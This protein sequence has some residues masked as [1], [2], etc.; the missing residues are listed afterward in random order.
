[1]IRFERSVFIMD[2]FNFYNSEND[3]YRGGLGGYV[4]PDPVIPNT[5]FQTGT[6]SPRKKKGGAARVVALTLRT[7]CSLP[8]ASSTVS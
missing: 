3:G 6:Q 4:D 5:P 1:M 8:S 7:R 2:E